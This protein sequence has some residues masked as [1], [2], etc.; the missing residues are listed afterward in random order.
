MLS[1]VW[2]RTGRRHRDESLLLRGIDDDND[3]DG[4]AVG[5]HKQVARS[6]PVGR[7]KRVYGPLVIPAV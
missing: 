6:G 4:L 1:I 5:E 3:G 7:L 2:R